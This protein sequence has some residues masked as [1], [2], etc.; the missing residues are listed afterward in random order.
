[1]FTLF[2]IVCVCVYTDV[3]TACTNDVFISTHALLM[4]LYDRDCRCSFTPTGHWLVRFVS[5]LCSSANKDYVFDFVC[6]LVLLFICSF[7][8]LFVMLVLLFVT[9]CQ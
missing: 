9:V 6:L 3:Q 8:F 5:K 1:M 4:T 7:A 2:F